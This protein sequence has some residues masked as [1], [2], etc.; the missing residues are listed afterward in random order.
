VV[1]LKNTSLGKQ[2]ISLEAEACSSAG[3][4]L[5]VISVPVATPEASRS[6]LI[7]SNVGTCTYDN[8]YWPTIK[9]KLFES[10]LIL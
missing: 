3:T 7:I 8:D 5:F 1:V 6:V 9:N 2:P 4:G 10:Q